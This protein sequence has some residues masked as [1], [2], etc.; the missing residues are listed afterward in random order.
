MSVTP[1]SEWPQWLQILIFLPH[2]LLASFMCWLWWPKSDRSW[3][4]FGFL[5]LYLLVFL[6]VMHYVFGLK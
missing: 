2:G 3:R 4:R 5:A 6:L 1:F